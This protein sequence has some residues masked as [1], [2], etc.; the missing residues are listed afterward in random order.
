MKMENKDNG[1]INPMQ[2]E[3]DSLA[4]MPCHVSGTYSEFCT[5]LFL[6]N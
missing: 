4:I 3:K 2:Y 1:A 5:S 6:L